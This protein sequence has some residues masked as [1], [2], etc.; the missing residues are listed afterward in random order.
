MIATVDSNVIAKPMQMVMNFQ[1]VPLGGLGATGWAEL[2]G[3][4]A[5]S[6]R[7]V[8]SRTAARAAIGGAA[9]FYHAFQWVIFAT[10]G[11]LARLKSVPF[12]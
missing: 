4:V 7:P 6:F 5:E 2:P 12:V 1:P 11:R 3:S 8:M 9:S 10:G